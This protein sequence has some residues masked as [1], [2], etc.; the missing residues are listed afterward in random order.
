MLAVLSPWCSNF[1]SDHKYNFNIFGHDEN[2]PLRQFSFFF[3]NFKEKKSIW[4]LFRA[5]VTTNWKIGF[6]NCASSQL[7]KLFYGGG[8]MNEKNLAFEWWLIKKKSWF[9]TAVFGNLTKNY[10]FCAWLTI[11]R[12][13]KNGFLCIT[14]PKYPVSQ[15]LDS[16]PPP[17]LRFMLFRQNKRKYLK[18][19][20]RVES[21]L[22][23]EKSEYAL[24][25]PSWVPAVIYPEPCWLAYYLPNDPYLA[26][27]KRGVT[28][29][30]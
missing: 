15:H 8:I 17:C 4:R 11:E 10:Y 13:G 22:N 25:H 9:L 2:A 19:H 27:A 5:R 29:N 21:N 20:E 14:I 18:K 3:F 12:V 1:S 16:F 7:L 24:G 6:S 30:E 28:K 23:L 26:V